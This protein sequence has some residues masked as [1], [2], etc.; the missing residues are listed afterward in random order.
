MEEKLIAPCG[1]N[2]AVCS[3]YL[4]RSNSLKSK[5]IG[6]PYCSGCRERDKQCAFLKKRCPTLQTGQVSYCYEC[7]EFPCAQLNHLDRRYRSLYHMSMIENLNLIKKQGIAALLERETQKWRCPS[8]GATLCCHNGRCFNCESAKLRN[9]K[10]LFRWEDDL[11][12]S[13]K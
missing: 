8:C 12:Q 6:I 1:M 2:C 9:K 5:G 7:S 3:S 10:P 13:E 4:S 11:S